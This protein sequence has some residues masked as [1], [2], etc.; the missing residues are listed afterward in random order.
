MAFEYRF[1]LINGNLGSQ[2]ISEPEGWKDI[3]FN[4]AWDDDSHSKLFTLTTPLRFYGKT[5]RVDGGLRFLDRI[6]RNEGVDAIVSLKIETKTD[7]GDFVIDIIGRLAL[8]DYKRVIGAQ[9]N[10][11]ECPIEETSKN[12]ILKSRFNAKVDFSKSE[13]LDGISIVPLRT[14][15]INLHS[16]PIFKE[17]DANTQLAETT[18]VFTISNLDSSSVFFG[19]GFENVLVDELATFNIGNYISPDGPISYLQAPDNG[20]YQVDFTARIAFELGTLEVGDYNISWYYRRNEEP[21]TL[22]QTI[23]SGSTSGPGVSVA[24]HTTT[25]SFSIDL[26]KGDE[27]FI[28]GRATI[29]NP[30]NQRVGYGFAVFPNSSLR[31]SSNTTAPESTLTAPLIHEAF[32]FICDSYFGE[33]NTFYSELLGNKLTQDRSYT[34]NGCFSFLSVCNG[35]MIRRLLQNFSLSFQ[36]LFDALNSVVPVGFAI[37]TIDGQEV[38]RI[39]HVSYFYN[40][41]VVLTIDSIREIR[42]TSNSERFYNT[43]KSGYRNWELE[44]VNGIKE[45]NSR[46]EHSTILKTVGED[47]DIES[48][49][50]TSGYIIETIRRL[51]EETTTDYKFDNNNFFIDLNHNESGGLPTGLNTAAR[52][53]LFTSVTGIDD[54]SL[55]YNLFLLPELNLL[56]HGTLINSGLNSYPGTDIVPNYFEG[57]NSFEVQLNTTCFGNFNNQVFNARNSFTWNYADQLDVVPVFLPVEIEFEHPLRL[58]EFRTITDNVNRDSNGNLNRN[59]AIR[60]NDFFGNG[61]T[62]FLIDIKHNPTEPNPTWRCLLANTDGFNIAIEDVSRWLD[63]NGGLVIDNDNNYIPD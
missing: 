51:V 55:Q 58:S 9:R 23:T 59:K 20:L 18:N 25:T 2:E 22:I 46:R 31:I 53:E 1:T 45:P 41:D 63:M 62:V 7:K 49:F 34:T 3:R 54:S 36:D 11:I 47:Y 60:I 21:E 37:E 6:I 5:D 33:D 44:D 32:R 17:Y 48:N 12:Q 26:Q 56:R 52:D 30:E 50:I 4:I 13:S 27:L 24:D 38:V 61:Y 43:I 15:D 35:R 29:E 10:Y 40:Q 8:R 19:I 57:F 39:E 16:L 14:R 42:L 28:Y